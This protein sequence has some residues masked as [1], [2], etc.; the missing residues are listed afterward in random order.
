M[1]PE[2]KL[3]QQKSWVTAELMLSHP[4]MTRDEAE[5]IYERAVSRRDSTALKFLASEWQA[6]G[7]AC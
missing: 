3:A 1:T 6:A 5:T 7:R 2:Q 4:E